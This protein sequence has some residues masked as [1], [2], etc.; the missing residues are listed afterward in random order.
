MSGEGLFLQVIHGQGPVFLSC[1]GALVMKQLAQGEAFVI[2]TGH[3]VAF[4]QTVQYRVRKV[5]NG[6]LASVGT[7]EGLVC[8]YTGPGRVLYQTRN[9][10][11]F[12]ELLKTH[13]PA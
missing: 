11:A 1:F 3:M 7:G 6:F 5:A 13:V 12:A 4:E 8:E 10:D 9:L 2:D